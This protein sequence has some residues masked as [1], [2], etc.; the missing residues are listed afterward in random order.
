MFSSVM[1][2]HYC[3]NKRRQ[4]ISTGADVEIENETSYFYGLLSTMGVI[5]GRRGRSRS[6]TISDVRMRSRNAFLDDK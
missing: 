1:S 2:L 6:S 4:S 3:S 5:K